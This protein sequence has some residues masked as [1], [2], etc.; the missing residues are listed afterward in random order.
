MK[1]DPR[2]AINKRAVNL[3]PLT[4]RSATAQID[5]IAPP[6]TRSRLPVT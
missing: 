6:S 3:V 4:R 1:Q 2:L 5:R